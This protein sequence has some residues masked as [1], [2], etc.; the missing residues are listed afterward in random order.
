MILRIVLAKLRCW[1]DGHIPGIGYRG[2]SVC[3]RCGARVRW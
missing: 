3:V 1:W 2:A